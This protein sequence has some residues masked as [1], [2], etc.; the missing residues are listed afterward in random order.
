MT[1]TP[2]TTTGAAS[3]PP[4]VAREPRSYVPLL[5]LANFGVYVALLT[6]VL[7]SLALKVRDL[8]GPDR[9]NGSLSTVL[10]VGALCALIANPLAGRLSDRT[11]SRFG[12]RRPWIV[13]GSV[14]GFLSLVLIASAHSI[15]LLTLGWCLAQVTF[16]GV[17]AAVNASLPDQ[18]PP[19]RRGVPSG[20]VGMAAPLAILGGSI[21]VNAFDTDAGRFLVP[22]A[23]GLVLALL[24]AVFLKD[25]RAEGPRSH[26]GLRVFLGSFVFDP[27]EHRDFGWV[28]LTKFLFMFG[29]VGVSTFLPYYLLNDLGVS[30]HRVTHVIVLVNFFGVGATLLTSLVGGYISDRIG[31]RK[32][33][34]FASSVTMGIGLVVLAFAPSIPAVYVAQTLIGLGA[35]TFFAVDLALATQVLPNPDDIAKD[36]GV[37][38]MANALPQSIAPALAVPVMAIGAAIGAG[39]YTFWYLFGAVL[40]ALAGVLI[41]RVKGVE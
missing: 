28:W 38:N 14:A 6:P 19:E 7:V 10:A 4:S 22:G 30:E 3:T 26:L 15:P 25:R 40:T 36:L 27:R 39:R 29:Y 32:P 24:L 8:V 17:L 37:L 41:Y 20:I 31:R 1:N 11:T 21:L 13:G 35:G 18:V 2:E 16:N 23:I 9:A 5:G 34:L 12:K 33:L